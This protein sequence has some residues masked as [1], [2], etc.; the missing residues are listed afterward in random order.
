MVTVSL[1]WANRRVG[2][3]LGGGPLCWAVKGQP[4]P[5][6]KTAAQTGPW[7]FGNWE[8]RGAG[9]VLE[10]MQGAD[11]NSSQGNLSANERKPQT[12]SGQLLCPPGLRNTGTEAEP[13]GLHLTGPVAPF[14]ASLPLSSPLD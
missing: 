1:I 13:L 9:S 7:G 3:Q 6:D 11:E 14:V 8:G 2:A 12:G 10:E 5:A 4:A